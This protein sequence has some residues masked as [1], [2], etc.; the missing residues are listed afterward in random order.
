MILRFHF[1][2]K[3]IAAKIFLREANAIV[4][5]QLVFRVKNLNIRSGM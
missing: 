4:L 5:V 2:R 1:I 3:D